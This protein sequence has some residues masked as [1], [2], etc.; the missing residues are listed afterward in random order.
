MIYE[1]GILRK[2]CSRCSCIET[3]RNTWVRSWK[4]RRQKHGQEMPT[5]AMIPVLSVFARPSPALGKF[6]VFFGPENIHGAIKRTCWQKAV[7]RNG[8]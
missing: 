8:W 5:E 1:L 6:S 7:I 2:H 4:T 3:G